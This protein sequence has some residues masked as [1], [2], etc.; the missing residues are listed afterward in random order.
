M[1]V[2]DFGA[3]SQGHEGRDRLRRPSEQA[4]RRLGHRPA[5]VRRGQG[6]RDRRRAQLR[7]WRS[8]STRSRGT[9]TRR[10]IVSSAATSDLTGK[11]CSP[12]TDPLDLRH[13]GAGQR[14]RQRHRQDGRRHAGSSSPP[15]TPS[16]T[17]SSATPRRSCSRTAARCWARCATRSTPPDFSSFLLQAQASKAKI[18]GLANAG[19]DTTNA[20]KQGAGVRHR[21]GRPE[22]RR[23]P[24]LPHRRARPRAREGPG[25]ALHRDLLLGPER[26]DARLREALRRARPGHPPDH[27]PRRRLRRRA[28]LPQGGRGAQVATTAPRSS[29]R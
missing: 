6:G 12:N 17:R 15:T 16:A 18:I 21:Q 4:R 26:Q 23:P 20:I 11:A 1:A 9:R 28:A 24:R 7:A 19:G 13:L 10:F 14:H 8:P 25:A 22:L 29:P 5:V 27:D 3:G 2:E